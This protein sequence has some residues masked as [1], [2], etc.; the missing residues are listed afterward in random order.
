[1]AQT[2]KNPFSEAK[3]LHTLSS[4]PYLILEMPNNDDHFSA[5]HNQLK[6]EHQDLL[7]HLKDKSPDYYY[8]KVLIPSG[9]T[10]KEFIQ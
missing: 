6:L 9:R 3:S 8:E 7:E 5:S 1:M 4:L 2:I 10:L